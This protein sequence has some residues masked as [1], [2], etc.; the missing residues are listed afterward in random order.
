MSGSRPG[1]GRAGDV[2]RQDA[3][4][5]ARTVT[6]DVGAV[7]VVRASREGVLR[8]RAAVAPVRSHTEYA[9]ESGRIAA[10]RR[11]APIRPT[12]NM[13]RSRT[14]RPPAPGLRSRRRGRGRPSS[15]GRTEVQRFGALATTNWRR[16]R[17]RP[18]GSR[19]PR[20]R[21][22]RRPGPS[23]GEPLV[24]GDDWTKL[25]PHGASVVP[26]VAATRERAGVAAG[27][28]W[29]HEGAVTGAAPQSG[30][31]STPGKLDVGHEKTRGERHQ[32]VFD[33]VEAAPSRTS[34]AR[35]RPPHRDLDRSRR[36]ARPRISEPAA[37][38]ANSGSGRT[39]VRDHQRGQG[40]GAATRTPYRC[41]TSPIR[42]W[43]LMTPRRDPRSW[44]R[45][46]AA[47][48]SSSTHNSW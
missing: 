2:R 4:V 36:P 43:P 7:E 34:A 25:S 5:A 30:C 10:A 35:R 20:R 33:A 1:A 16:T 18:S 14:D 13:T 32:Q 28:A 27:Q 24:H 6:C 42:P 22:V 11:P 9:V 41:R 44:N 48:E 21:S 37:T 29:G 26:T 40:Q 39:D 12:P 38:P 17:S 23:D 47:V 31:A 45:I 46:S 15:R 8:S 19:R 3:S